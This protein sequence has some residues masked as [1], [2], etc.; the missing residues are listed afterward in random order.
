MSSKAFSLVA[1]AIF[2]VV[3]VAHLLRIFMALPVTIGD[4]IIPMWVS[5]MAVVVAG[6]LSYSGLRFAASSKVIV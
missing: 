5:W 2:G 6:W 3:A 4:W 1:G